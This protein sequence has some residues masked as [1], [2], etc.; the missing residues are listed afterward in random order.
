[1]R[2][3]WKTL[4]LLIALLAAAGVISLWLTLF[5]R[6]R[7]LNSAGPAAPLTEPVINDISADRGWQTTGILLDSGMTIQFQYLS[8]EIRDGETIL[9]GPSGSGYIC[10]DST[11]C[12]PMPEVQRAALIGRVKDHLLVIADKNTIEVQESGELQLRINDCDE[13]LFD[14]SGSLKVKISP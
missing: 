8:G 7:S 4:V 2:S 5:I 9:R 10:G 12:E 11:C 1:M 14:N 13:G 6:D 3:S